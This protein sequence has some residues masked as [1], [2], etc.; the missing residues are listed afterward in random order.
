MIRATLTYLHQNRWITQ[1]HGDLIICYGIDTWQHTRTVCM[2]VDIGM[3]MSR[4]CPLAAFGRAI[5]ENNKG[6]KMDKNAISV[7]KVYMKE[8]LYQAKK[9]K[10]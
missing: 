3:C 10:G 2:Q 6:A 7:L 5:G 1:D 8:G 9:I 4:T